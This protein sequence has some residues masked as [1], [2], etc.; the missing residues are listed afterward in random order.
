MNLLHML[1]AI[2]VLA[3]AQPAKPTP[4]QQLGA[5]RA[6]LA[7]ARDSLYKCKEGPRRDSR[8]RAQ[9]HA[10]T[11]A[12]QTRALEGHRSQTSEAPPDRGLAP[13]GFSSTDTGGEIR[14]QDLE[15]GGPGC[16]APDRAVGL[17]DGFGLTAGFRW[18]RETVCPTCPHVCTP[19]P[20][21][22]PHEEQ[23][24]PFF[25]GAE[26][27]LPLTPHVDAF[28]NLDRDWTEAAHWNAR[29]GISVR[30]WRRVR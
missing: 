19:A 30:P 14:R 15:E 23:K 25:V 12:A 28:G 20:P 11:A 2:T 4:E 24:D 29:V 8:H 13:R 7:A 27:R 26:L 6:A 9:A 5:T 10:T 3:T 16:G 22:P 21:P 1:A 17:L 18:D